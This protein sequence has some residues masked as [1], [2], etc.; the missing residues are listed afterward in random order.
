MGTEKQSGG[1]QR[2]PRARERAIPH[3]TSVRLP[4]DLRERLDATASLSGRSIS[5]EIVERLERTFPKG[6]VI[7][8][9][10]DGQV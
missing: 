9:V 1:S 5:A 8:E 7:R 10:L 6:A 4:E 3:P 2:A